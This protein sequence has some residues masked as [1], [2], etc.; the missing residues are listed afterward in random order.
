MTCGL[1]YL[2]DSRGHGFFLLVGSPG[3][4]CGMSVYKN[5]INGDRYV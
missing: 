5:Y 1:Q 3:K 2:V 4:Y